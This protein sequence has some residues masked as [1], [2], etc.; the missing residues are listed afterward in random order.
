MAS[1]LDKIRKLSKQRATIIDQLTS[2]I[3]SLI[4]DGQKDLYQE[5]IRKY[6]LKELSLFEEGKLKNISG[7]YAST[8]QLDK[9]WDKQFQKQTG[10]KIVRQIIE[11]TRDITKV[12]VKYFDLFDK[13]TVKKISDQIQKKVLNTYGI[14]PD[15]DIKPESILNQAFKATDPL[16]K[17]KGSI[18]AAIAAEVK[19]SDLEASLKTALIDENL[20]KKYLDNTQVTNVFD[21]YDRQ[22]A[23]EYSS[24]LQ[25]DFAIYQ[26]G[27]IEDSRDF[28]I[29]RN[30][31][32]FTREEILAFGTSKDKFGGYTNKSAG[33]FRGKWR[34]GL[35]VY[36]P[37]QDMGCYNCRHH[38]DWISY[39]L[40]SRLRP[41]LKK[42]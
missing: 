20:L 25:L 30:G 13:A 11:G 35:K 8:F 4:D 15:G 39:E 42:K 1:L 26:G 10:D 24:A 21:R 16:N 9:I 31:K 29:E 38:W 12:N 41:E 34:P 27:I 6:L 19:L 3:Y 14:T 36:D 40:A 18:H 32:V 5:I 17:I 22:T 23:N 37:L 7:N 2:D 33:E 28:C